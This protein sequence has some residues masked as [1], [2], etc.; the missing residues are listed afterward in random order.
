MQGQQDQYYMQG[1]V[2][3]G[4]QGQY[5]PQGQQGFPHHGP[6]GPH[7]P[8]KCQNCGMEIQPPHGPHGPPQF[9]QGQQG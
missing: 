2:Q 5:N 7:G 4:I 1:Q 3:P 6:H 8:I 9:Q